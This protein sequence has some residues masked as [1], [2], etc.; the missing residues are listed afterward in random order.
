MNLVFF[1][2]TSLSLVGI[3]ILGMTHFANAQNNSTN[4]I[5]APGLNADFKVGTSANENQE[6]AGFDEEAD[7]D[8]VD[9]D[10]FSPT[11]FQPGNKKAESV[12][13]KSAICT[14]FQTDTSLETADWRSFKRAP[15]L[16]SPNA[17]AR[18]NPL[19]SNAIGFEFA[20]CRKLKGKNCNP[21]VLNETT[22]SRR[23]KKSHIYSEPT[24]LGLD[25]V[26]CPTTKVCKARLRVV[27]EDCK[28]SEWTYSELVELPTKLQSPYIHYIG[29]P[30]YYDCYV[31]IFNNLVCGYYYV[32]NTVS[33]GWS[34]VNGA[35]SYLLGVCG[36]T[37]Y[38]SYCYVSG[39]SPEQLDVLYS[40]YSARTR[41][42][43]TDLVCANRDTCVVRIKAEAGNNSNYID[44]D[45]SYSGVVGNID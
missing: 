25:E 10:S 34:Y 32:D 23:Y 2:K 38:A 6:M 19:P 35:V 20:V 24:A 33:L 22:L 44:S 15:Y 40:T 28:V 13:R 12:R 9:N 36:T 39:N 42:T 37:G 41:A 8:Q 16:A 17:D 4:R 18:W 5:A 45:W 26:F 30:T 29:R 27:Y 21:A 1:K 31:D 11:P 14:E 43:E 7:A 3:F